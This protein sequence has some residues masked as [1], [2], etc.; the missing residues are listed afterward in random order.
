MTST[1]ITF[2]PENHIPDFNDPGLKY[3]LDLYHEEDD[4]AEKVIRVKRISLPNDGSR[5]KVMENDKVIFTLEGTD[6]TKREREYLL[7]VDGFNFLLLQ[8]KIG[9]ESLNVFRQNLKDKLPPKPEKPKKI[10]VK[11]SKPRG[12]PRIIRKIE[13]SY[14]GSI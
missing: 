2:D 13:A 12:R 5:W 3:N 11:K 8:A 9:I 10:K 4:I 6:L 14:L 1:H 7:T